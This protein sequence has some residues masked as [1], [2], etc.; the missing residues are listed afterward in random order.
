MKYR[1]TGGADG[2]SGIS[3]GSRRYEAGDTLD[4]PQS[5]AQWLIDRGLLEPVSARSSTKDEPVEEVDELT[6]DGEL[7]G[8]DV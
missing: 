5:K 1:V 7:E 4:M 2:A 8:D 3:V 6:P